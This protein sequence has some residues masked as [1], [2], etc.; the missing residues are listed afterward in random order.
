[1]ASPTSLVYWASYFILTAKMPKHN[2]RIGSTT[3]SLQAQLPWVF[4][5]PIFYCIM[6]WQFRC[7]LLLT[8]LHDLANRRTE[9]EAEAAGK[10]SSPPFQQLE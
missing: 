9:L 6:T 3:C 10:K 7:Q 1:M 8:F 5:T 4:M 2:C